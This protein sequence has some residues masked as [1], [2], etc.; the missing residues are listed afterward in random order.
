MSFIIWEKVL[1]IFLKLNSSAVLSITKLEN[2]E[3]VAI[4]I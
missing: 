4:I 3:G 1:N 2:K